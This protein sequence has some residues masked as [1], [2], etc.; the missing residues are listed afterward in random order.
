MTLQEAVKDKNRPLSVSPHEWMQYEQA[1][2]HEEEEL[3][4]KQVKRIIEDE[5][6][7]QNVDININ[8]EEKLDVGIEQ[9]ILGC[10]ISMKA[11]QQL[12]RQNVTASQ[13]PVYNEIK[14][15][16]YNAVAPYLADILKSRKGLYK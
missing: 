1:K 16:I 8:A 12:D 6:P 2:E 10:R 5:N 4:Q 7:E 15:L 11:L 14:S 3:I 9:M 13:R